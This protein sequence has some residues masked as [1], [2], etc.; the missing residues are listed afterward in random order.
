[1][2]QLTLAITMGGV[3]I[4]LAVLF[5]FIPRLTRQDLYFA[6]TVPAGF[7]DELQGKSI[8]RQ[9]RIE[10]ILV[11]ALG[12]TAV[13]AGIVWLGVGFVP[14]G[15]F[16]QLVACFIVF[17]RARQRALPY[18]VPPT[19]IREAELHARASIIH[20]GWLAALGPF[21][22]LAAFVAYLWIQGAE[23]PARF[24]N[25][26]GS[27]EQPNGLAAHGV[28]STYFLSVGGILTALTLIL[29]GLGHWVR[30]I[31]ASGPEG[32]RELKFRRTVSAM[33][34][35][36]QYYITLQASWIALVP[37]PHALS[38]ITLLPLAFVLVLFAIVV[39]ARLGQGGSRMQARE[40][41]ASAA[42][43]GPVGDRTPDCCWKLG[44]FYFN[45]DDSA[46]LI[47][48][49]FCLG[50]SLNFARPIA[51]IIVLL[52]LMGPLIPILTHLRSFFLSFR[53]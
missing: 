50:Y 2:V 29:Y 22:L 32:A 24:T 43:A 20:G 30:P 36:T 23:T 17:Y 34:L 11:S 37:V 6:V 9:Y 4:L 21:I 48:K 35:L 38:T 12:F 44:I 49:R 39:L 41:R 26:W 19:M 18:A 3:A 47:E 33:L 46:V 13:V 27:N 15:Y 40:E 10:L 45:R 28:V 5:W 53:V 52:A 42:S 16:I 8:L 1:M 25:H 31:H 14:G 7:M 51:W